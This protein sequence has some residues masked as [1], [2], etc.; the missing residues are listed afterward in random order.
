M[1]NKPWNGYYTDKILCSCTDLICNCKT[2]YVL[3]PD[4][5]IVKVFHDYIKAKAYKDKLNSGYRVK[6]KIKDLKRELKK[7]KNKLKKV[8][9]GVK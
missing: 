7:Q 2:W 4:G 9:K 1:S 8:K 5:K 3:E 6:L